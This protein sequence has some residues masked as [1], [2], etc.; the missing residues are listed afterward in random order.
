MAFVWLSKI[1]TSD[2]IYTDNSL[3]QECSTEY[4]LDNVS[5]GCF[6]LS[7][8]GAMIVSVLLWDWYQHHCTTQMLSH[9]GWKYRNYIVRLY[10][11][12]FSLNVCGLPANGD[13]SRT[14]ELE[15]RDLLVEKNKVMHR[16]YF[17]LLPLNFGFYFYF[18]FYWN[19]IWKWYIL[20]FAI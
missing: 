11:Y 2:G 10:T 18:H 3:C 5:S 12:I 9:H 6:S 7:V 13:V 8:N 14:F 4:F 20:F 17:N 1:K 19:Y 16:E 15:L